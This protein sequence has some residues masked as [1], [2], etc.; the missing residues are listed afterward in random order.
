L[1]VPVL[2]ITEPLQ[3]LSTHAFAA[4]SWSFFSS[5]GNLIADIAGGTQQ[6][7]PRANKNSLGINAKKTPPIL[8]GFI[9]IQ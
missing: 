1:P 3:P 5:N 9:S 6:L 8:Y 4:S 7:E 2:K